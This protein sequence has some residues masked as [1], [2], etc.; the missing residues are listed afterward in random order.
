[1]ASASVLAH[2]IVFVVAPVLLLGGIFYG[3]ET[4]RWGRAVFFMGCAVG[5]VGVF[6]FVAWFGK[7]KVS[8][9]L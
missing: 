9:Y 6:A 4:R 1:M 8:P 5:I 3:I 2:L 7:M